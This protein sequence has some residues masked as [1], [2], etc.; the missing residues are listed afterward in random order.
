MSSTRTDAVTSLPFVAA[1]N[2]LNTVDKVINPICCVPILATPPRI[3]QIAINTLGLIGTTAGGVATSAISI[4]PLPGAIR[5]RVTVWKDDAW[6]LSSE[7]VNKIAR[8]SVDAV[9]FAGPRILN[10]LDAA[11]ANAARL[12]R[13]YTDLRGR[14]LTLASEREQLLQD[15]GRLREQNRALMSDHQ[16]IQL[17]TTSRKALEQHAA[18]REQELK[19]LVEEKSEHEQEASALKAQ[20]D[21]LQE[22]LR[23]IS[24][25]MQ[26]LTSQEEEQQK[27]V[28]EVEQEV[29]SSQRQLET[30]VKAVESA[31]A[32]E[33]KMV[34]LSKQMEEL[35][36]QQAALEADSAKTAQHLESLMSSAQ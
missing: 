16:Q 21:E 31:R 3:V 24:K 13:E 5:G 35:A 18:E 34:A 8:L 22:K 27:A 14:G 11:V 4:A 25:Q 19:R 12:T 26:S 17:L 28:S 30:A 10:R 29:V 36:S 1:R 15:N 23:R 7:L 33:E 20:V 9:P 6:K 32:L 2:I